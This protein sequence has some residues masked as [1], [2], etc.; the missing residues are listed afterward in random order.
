ML[1]EQEDGAVRV[2][3]ADEDQ[4]AGWRGV[5]IKRPVA[6]KGRACG[7]LFSAQGREADEIGD[8]V[9]GLVAQLGQRSVMKA[10]PDF[11]DPAAI[12]TFDAVLEAGL[13]GRGEDGRDAQA[14]TKPGN[15]ADDSGMV[16]R[17]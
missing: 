8:E 13:M 3:A 16:G 7:R 10:L 6:W 5:K 17:A 9:L 1:A 4:R 12:K 11:G 2:G 14:Q 15:A